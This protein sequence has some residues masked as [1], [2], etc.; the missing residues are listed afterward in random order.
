MNLLCGSGFEIVHGQKFGLYIPLVS[1][2]L[3]LLLRISRRRL[4][5]SAAFDVEVPRVFAVHFLA[6]CRKPEKEA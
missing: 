2:F 3:E 4:P 1:P 6:E 5:I